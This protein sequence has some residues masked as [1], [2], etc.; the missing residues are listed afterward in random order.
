MLPQPFEISK[1]HIVLQK[2]SFNAKESFFI[3]NLKK[4]KLIIHSY[5]YQKLGSFR[6]NMIIIIIGFVKSDLFKQIYKFLN[7]FKYL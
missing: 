5:I 1:S 2:I 3:P 6:I 7:I 4:I